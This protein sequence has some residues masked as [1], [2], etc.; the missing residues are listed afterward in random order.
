METVINAS[1]VKTLFDG[2]KSARNQ[3]RSLEQKTTS[4]ADLAKLDILS[5]RI[6]KLDER[7]QGSGAHFVYDE[8]IPELIRIQTQLANL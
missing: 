2:I 7:A 4:I 1:Q 3:I 6:A 8:L 5:E